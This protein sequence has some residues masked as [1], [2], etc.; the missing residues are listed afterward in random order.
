VAL[1]GLRLLPAAVL[2]PFL[3]G[4]LVPAGVRAALA[5]GLGGCAWMATGGAPFDAPSL[6]LL[7]AAVREILLGVAMGFL[8]SVPFEAA[9]AGGRLV[10]TMRGA[11]LTELHVAPLRQRESASGDMLVHWTVV[12]GATAGGG[13]LVLAA[14]L[15]T[16]RSIPIGAGT[17]TQPLLSVTLRGAGEILSCALALGAPAAAGVLAADLVLSAIGRAAPHLQ[18]SPSAQPARAGVALVALLFPAAA[19]AGRLTSSVALSSALLRSL[20]QGVTP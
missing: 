20:A 17:P 10:D 2:C 8:A 16:F 18:L 4:P 11:T 1:H 9:R 5:F 7:G 14:L 13:R 19:L 3:G 15:D 12:L 6:P